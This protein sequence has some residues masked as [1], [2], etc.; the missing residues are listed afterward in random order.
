VQGYTPSVSSGLSPRSAYL[1]TKLAVFAVAAALTWPLSRVVG[2]RAW[3]G[4][5]VFG[6]I[7]ALL[8]VVVV[9]AT[10]RAVATPAVSDE[11]ADDAGPDQSA[12]VVLPIEDSLDL[13]SFPPRDIPKVVEDYLE[14]AHG[15]GFT[16][17]RLIHGRGVGFQRE[18]VRSVLEKHP[19]VVSYRDATPDRGGWGAT[20]A[21]LLQGGIEA[22]HEL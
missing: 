12:P 4:L 6:A 2:P 15:V 16:E 9:V 21:S 17:V 7:L 19:L 3:W 1:L 18:R 10:S 11:Q 5:A 20:I 8:S 22:N 13:H 14:Q